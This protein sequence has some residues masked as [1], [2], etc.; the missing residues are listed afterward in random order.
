MILEIEEN[1]TS[2]L[3]WLLLKGMEQTVSIRKFEIFERL[4][5]DLHKQQ[6]IKT[7]VMR[8]NTTES[9]ITASVYLN[10]SFYTEIGCADLSELFEILSDHE[11]STEEA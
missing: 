4:S 3:K 11:I 2:A 10:G 6:D 1:E 8:I 9:S 5:D 7:L